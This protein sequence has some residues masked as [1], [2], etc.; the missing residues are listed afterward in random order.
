MNKISCEICMDLIPLVQDGVAS[1]DSR[2]AVA[3]HIAGCPACRALFDGQPPPESNGTQLL[4]QIQH[5]MQLFFVMLMMIGIFFGVSLL[6]GEDMFYNVLIMPVIGALG[7]G[8]SRWNALYQVPILLLVVHILVQ[9][10]GLIRGVERFDLL[11]L[12]WWTV[13]LAMF[14]LL[15][16]VITGLFHYAFRK[17]KKD[18]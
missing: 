12:L 7:Y 2:Q 14:V 9:T 11:S 4:M 8:V 5:K 15:G 10:L 13:I 1:A 17:E 6:A 18:E 3:D 16:T